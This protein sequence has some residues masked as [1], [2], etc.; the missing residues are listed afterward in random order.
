MARDDDLL[1][2]FASHG[3]P[4]GMSDHARRREA[5]MAEVK[6][7]RLLSR[8][9]S[10]ETGHLVGIA[11]H[12]QAGQWAASVTPP[13]GPMEDRWVNGDDSMEHVMPLG[14]EDADVPRRLAEGFRSPDF[15][16]YMRKTIG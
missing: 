3:P 1:R 15:L 9:Q 16:D 14:D 10:M 6:R 8:R 13:A 7:Q 5:I 12:P 11:W 2:H 4:D